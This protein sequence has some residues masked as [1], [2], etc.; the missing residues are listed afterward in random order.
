MNN[1]KIHLLFVICLFIFCDSNFKEEEQIVDKKLKLIFYVIQNK[2]CQS[3]S[4]GD[5][6]E[7]TR[8]L[9]QPKRFH[10]IQFLRSAFIWLVVKAT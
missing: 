1:L 8:D 3:K 9:W 10:V 2:R 6:G 7:S 4:Q 5:F